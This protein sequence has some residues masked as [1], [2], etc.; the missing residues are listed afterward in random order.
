MRERAAASFGRQEAGRAIKPDLSEQ[1]IAEIQ[2]QNLVEVAKAHPEAVSYAIKA[3]G[4]WKTIWDAAVDVAGSIMH[5]PAFV[6]ENF[7][8]EAERAID[9]IKNDP[10]KMIEFLASVGVKLPDSIK[11][12]IPGQ[13]EFL[14]V[15]RKIFL[16][17]ELLRNV[18]MSFIDPNLKTFS[19]I[20]KK[21]MITDAVTSVL[22]DKEKAESFVKRLLSNE[23]SLN[24]FYKISGLDDTVY[25][26]GLS[27]DETIH[28]GIKGRDFWKRDSEEN[29][30]AGDYPKVLAEAGLP[31]PTENE[32]EQDYEKRLVQILRTGSVQ[33]KVRIGTALGT[34]RA[35]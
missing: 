5:G 9:H 16:D 22:G 26:F 20:D 31:E 25:A 24:R 3:S 2:L 30:M 34:A 1:E 23:H 7:V 32:T 4:D 14:D 18:V 29:V 19:G 33:E 35:H 12:T 11:E 8:A 6:N 27:T 28:W 17:Q 13:V 10:K 15:A 21:G